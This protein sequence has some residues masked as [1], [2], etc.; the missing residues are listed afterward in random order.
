METALLEELLQSK[1]FRNWSPAPKSESAKPPTISM[2]RG[3]SFTYSGKR[4]TNLVVNEKHYTIAE[5]AE[6]W[7]ISTDLARDTFRNEDGVLKFDRPGSRVKRSYS[8]L[9]VP[10]SVMVRV[11][12]RLTS[13]K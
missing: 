13:G 1:A 3:R 8:T 6:Q 4:Y 11:H 5:I 7:G 2:G 12:T 10:E 9:R